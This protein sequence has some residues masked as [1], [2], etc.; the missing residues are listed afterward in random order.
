[1]NP[2]QG[3]APD[4][5]KAGNSVRKKEVTA[6]GGKGGRFM[7]IEKEIL[8]EL[9]KMTHLECNL[10]LLFYLLSVIIFY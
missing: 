5:S 4:F 9:E 7:D 3:N 1:M 10:F 2:Q 6:R 8:R